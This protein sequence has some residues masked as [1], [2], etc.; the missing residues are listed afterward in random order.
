LAIAQATAT[1]LESVTVPIDDSVTEQ[2]SLPVKAASMAA[3]AALVTMMTV[4]GPVTGHPF[5]AVTDLDLMDV[6][7]RRLVSGT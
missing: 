5:V 6:P 1:A 2:V 7:Q 3:D 4:V